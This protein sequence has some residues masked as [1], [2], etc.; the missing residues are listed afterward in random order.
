M[1][2]RTTRRASLGLIG[3]AA[4]ATL[5]IAAHGPAHA[6]PPA[7]RNATT[8][9]AQS[10]A[11]TVAP[12]VNPAMP[13]RRY[14]DAQEA[15]TAA[16][17]S[18]ATVPLPDGGNFNGI[19]FEEADGLSAADVEGVLEHNAACQWW[20]ALSDARMRGI[21]ARIAA[22][23][24]S[25]P[26]FR[27]TEQAELAGQVAEQLGGTGGPQADG[28]LRDCAAMHTREVAYASARGWAPS[29]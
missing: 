25:W 8:L 11:L 2:A 6:A 26:S 5:A 17:R 10:M 20:R 23:I 18:A 16:D 27:G 28:V 4:A 7:P 24:P 22:D 29:S 15:R 1:T 14:A 13:G 9:E 12:A 21:A 19:R 3:A